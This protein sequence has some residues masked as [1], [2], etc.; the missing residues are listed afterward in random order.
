MEQ[1]LRDDLRQSVVV[2][3][4]ELRKFLRGKK[5][6]LFGAVIAAVLILLT[7]LPYLLGEGYQEEM[8]LSF[9]FITFVPLIIELAGILF[10][11][12]SLV[13]EY[14]DRTALI[15]FTRPIRK[16]SI[17][18]GK[19]MA[20]VIVMVV[21]SIFYYAFTIAFSHLVVGACVDTMWKSFLLTFPGLYAVCGM[22][23]L[24][25]SIFKRGS[26]AS[27][28][29]MIVMVLMI[30][31][32]VTIVAMFSNLPTWWGFEE[33]LNSILYS[34]GDFATAELGEVFTDADLWRSA[35]VMV[36]WGTV[37]NILSYVIFRKRDF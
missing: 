4:N 12:T 6:L 26:T 27:I 17:F 8:T 28:M 5:M 1:G 36:V 9:V 2:T 35:Y 34:L 23:M 31:I 24:M 10:T 14:E 37:T 29:T 20:S 16:R 11:A 15:L 33:A 13:S 19:L 18:I 3:R 32:I 21:F 7:T 30:S 22:S 25:S